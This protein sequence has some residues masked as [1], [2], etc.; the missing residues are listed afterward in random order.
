MCGKVA[1]PTA[2]SELQKHSTFHTPMS[3][4]LTERRPAPTV[5][6]ADR[7]AQDVAYLTA[8]PGGIYAAWIAGD[9]WPNTSVPGASLF[10]RL[11][12][13]DDV[14]TWQRCGCATMVKFSGER[15][16]NRDLVMAA[17]A[18]LTRRIREDDRIP[19]SPWL[20]RPEHLAVFA[21]YQRECDLATGRKR[22]A[23]LT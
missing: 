4:T 11:A 16:T 19:T 14:A 8:N 15:Q 23:R 18:D 9:A 20:I 7:Y 17:T 3:A 21:S 2:A 10:R 13:E 5:E 22:P 12:D 1:K 6:R